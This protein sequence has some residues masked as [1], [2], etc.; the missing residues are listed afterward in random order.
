MAIQT[1]NRLL[2]FTGGDMEDFRGGDTFDFSGTP[3]ATV[4]PATY[5]DLSNLNKMDYSFP[6]RMEK[7]SCANGEFFNGIKDKLTSVLDKIKT[8]KEV[9]VATPP[10]ADGATAA[11]AKPDT[12]IFGFNPLT[13]GLGVVTAV[14]V[15][16]ASSAIIS[17]F[18]LKHKKINTPA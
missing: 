7:M 13:F 6:Q 3:T 1:N 5:I 18:V 2:G 17:H 14:A 15:I 8:S 4:G 10:P 16:W 11:D 9:P 12:T